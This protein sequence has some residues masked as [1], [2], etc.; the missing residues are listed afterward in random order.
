MVSNST[1]SLCGYTLPKTAALAPMA[2]VADTV[3]RTLSMEHGAA[4]CVSEMISAKG[5]CYDSKGSAELCRISEI[6]RPMALQLFG[7][8]PEFLARSVELLLPYAPDMIDFNMGCPV[9]KVVKTGA[10]SA[11]LKNPELARKCVSTLVKHSPVPVTCK[12][13]IGWDEQ[14]ICA[15]DFARMLEDVGASAI[16]VH[17]RTRSQ[18]YTGSADW[19]VIR[20]VKEAV[21]IPVIGNGDVTSG[22]SARTMYEQT[23]CDLVAVGRGSYGNP[24]IFEEITAYLTDKSYTPPTVESRMALML[25]HIERVLASSEKPPNLAI[26][27]VRGAAACYGTGLRGASAFRAR[28]YRLSSL[29]EARELAKEM[30]NAQRA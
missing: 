26:R 27:Q 29:E 19:S 1:V 12:I 11:L 9:T 28:C 15:V 5:L 21:Q 18:F 8:E 4:M 3:Y 7:A 22:E 17:A 24:W 2:G 14:S 23:G 20:D 16:T 6:E 30:C 13:R 25:E 10:G